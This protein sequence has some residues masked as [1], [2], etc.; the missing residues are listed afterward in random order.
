MDIRRY[1]IDQGETGRGGTGSNLLQAHDIGDDGLV[2]V[3]SGWN[4]ADYAA[5]VWLFNSR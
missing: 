1:K 2:K 5:V 3:A 4:R